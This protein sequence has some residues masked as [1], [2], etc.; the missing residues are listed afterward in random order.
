MRTQ[1][2]A[3]VV[4]TAGKWRPGPGV[5]SWYIVAACVLAEHCFAGISRLDHRAVS[6]A[7]PR[8]R[9]GARASSIP[10]A[11]AGGAPAASGHRCGGG[12]LVAV[13]AHRGA[14]TTDGGGGRRRPRA[15]RWLASPLLVLLA[16]L[17]ALLPSVAAQAQGITL[18][19]DGKIYLGLWS[20]YERRS[21]DYTVKLTT[22]PSADVTVTIS[23]GATCTD[24]GLLTFDTDLTTGGNQDTLT[25][26]SSNWNTAQTVRVSNGIDSDNADDYCQAVHTASGG[27]YVNVSETKMVVAQ[28]FNGEVSGDFT[29]QT[30]NGPEGRD[31]VYRVNLTELPTSDV[32][33]TITYKSGDTDI[34]VDTDAETNGNQNTLTFTVSNYSTLQKVTIKSAEDEDTERGQAIFTH[35][36]SG[37][38][39]E[40]ALSPSR[41]VTLYEVDDDDP[42]AKPEDLSASAGNTQVSL[43]WDQAVHPGRLVIDKWQYR[44]KTTGDYGSWT[45]ISGSKGT[46]TGHTVTGLTNDVLHTFEV[47]AHADVAGESSDEA[48]ATPH[49]PLSFGTASISDYTFARQ[50]TITTVTL[51]QA[52]G[53]VPSLTYSL[54]RTSGTP[55]LPPGLTFTASSR[56]LSGT[57]STLQTATGYT[58]TVTDSASPANTATLTVNIAVE[59]DSQPTLAAVSDQTFHEDSAI[60]NL[61]LPAASGGN[62]PLTYTLAKTGG[63]GIPAGLTFDAS[64]RTLSGTPDDHQ[65]AT[66][67]TYTV[68]DS[69]DD[70]ASQT[71]NITIT[72]DNDPSFGQSTVADQ[73]WAQNKAITNLTLPEATGGDGTTTYTLVRSSGTPT[74]PPGISFNANTRVVSGTPTTLQSD[75]GYTY[76]ATDSDSDTASLTFEITVE[77]DEA[78]T[79]GAVADQT[80]HEDSAITDFVLPEASGGNGTLTYTLT[81]TQGSGLPAGLS[82]DA[83]TRTLSGTPTEHQT[84]TSYTYTVTDSDSDTA[85]QTFD[86][87]ITE[88]NDPSFGSSTIAD[89]TW[90]QNAALTTLTL[91]EATGGDGVTTYTLERTSGTPTLPPGV[92]FDSSS[93]G[94]SGTPTTLQSDVGYTYTAT[95]GDGDTATLTFEITVETD[96]DVTLGA[97]ADQTYHEDSAIT[98]LVLPAAGGGNAPLIYT[99]AKT[100]G[101]GIPAGLTF[102][103]ATR[104]LSGTPD[105]HQTSTGYTYTVTD[106]DGDTA[107]QIFNIT[108]TEDNEPTFG[109]GTVPNQSWAQNEAI[110][111]QTLPA[112][113]GGDGV[114]TYTLART[115]GQPPLPPGI[116]FTATTRLLAGTP[117]TLQ[118]A[119]G[120]TYTATDGDGD[121]ATLTFTIA[122][123]ADS[124]PTLGSVADQ[125]FHEDSAITDLVLPAATNGNAPVS[126]TL[127]KT[128]GSGL[129]AGLTFDGPTRTLSGTPE[130]HQTATGYTYT[131]TD[132]DDDSATATFNITITQDTSPAFANN[133]SIADRVYV[134]TSAI[135]NE[136]FPAATGGQ[137]PLTYSLSP[138]LPTGLTFTA[139]SRELSGTPST[140]KAET[141]Y[142]YTVTDKDGDTDTLTF[143]LTVEEDEQPSFSST[144]TD[145]TYHQNDAITNLVLPAASGGN[146]PLSYTLAKTNDSGI[147]TGLTF[148]ASSRTLSGT[149]TEDQTATGYTYTVTDV[150][151]DTATLTFDIT[152]TEDTD[153]SFGSSTVADQTWTQNAAI[154]NLTLP[155]ATGGE[156]SKTYTLARSS[157]TPTLPPGISFNSTTR[158]VSGTPTTLQSDVGYTYTATDADDDTATLTF[159]I[160]VEADTDPTLAS[161]ANQ[162]FH[163]RSAITDLVLPAATNGNAPFT[164]TLAKTG[165][166]G[167]PAGL[168][169]DA[170]TRTLSGTPTAHQTATSYTYTVTD[171]E[172]DTASV[173]FNITITED[174]DPSFGANMVADQTWTQNDA[175]TNLT[176]PEATGGDGSTTYTL[177]R[178]SGTPTLPPGISFNADTRVVSGTPTTLQSDVGYTYTATDGDDDTATLTFE[179]TVEADTAPTLGAVTD[180]TYHQ[181]SAIADLVLPAATNGNAPLTYTLAKTGGSGIP[182]GLTFDATTRTLSGTPTG[183]QASTSYTYKVTDAQ[184]ESATATFNITITQDNSPS[185]G[186]NTIAD[187]TWTQNAAITNL[188]LP[189]ATGGDGSKTYTL[190]RTSGTPT[191]PP[192]I[193]FN[194]NTRVVSGTP[195][196]LQ[197]AIG[198]TYTAT[199]SDDDTATL[200]FEITVEADTTPTLGSIADQ[201]YFRDTAITNLVLPAAT[202]GNAPFTYSLAK[203]G[204]SGLPTGLSFN[205]GTR[206]LSGTPTVAQTATGYTYTVTDDEDD[207]ATATFDITISV[208]AAPTADAGADQS[209]FEA[210][211]VTLDGTGSSDPENQTLTY[212]WTQVPTP[213]ALTVTNAVTL[214]SATAASPTFTAPSVSANIVLTFS[215]T[216]SDSVGASSAADTV[217]VTVKNQAPAATGL[218]ATWSSGSA[219]LS[220]TNPNDAAVTGWEYRWHSENRSFGSTD[221][222]IAIPSSGASTSSYQTPVSAGGVTYRFQVRALNV[223]GGGAAS[224]TASILA[225]PLAPIGLKSVGGDKSVTIS[226]ADPSDTSI[227]SYEYRRKTTT[228]YSSWT[229]VT[230]SNASTTSV[231]V[232]SLFNGVAYGFQVRARN[233]TGPGGD[234]GDVLAYTI[235]GKPSLTATAGAGQVALSWRDNSNSVGITRWQ[236]RH[237]SAGVTEFGSW[238]DI[239]GSGA[240]TW[241]HTVTGLAPQVEYTFELRGVNPGGAGLASN[242]AKATPT[243]SAVTDVPA[244]PVLSVAVGDAK[245]RLSWPGL[246]DA[247][248]SRFEYKRKTAG[249]FGAVTHMVDSKATTTS[250]DVLSLTNGTTYGFVVRAVNAAGNSAWSNEV[251]AQLFL[252]PG[253]LTATPSDGGA[254]LSWTGNG[255]TSVSAWQ[256]HYQQDGGGYG[257]WHAMSGS[258]AST[259][260]HSVTGLD[261]GHSYTFRIRPVRTGGAGPL[262][263]AAT[264]LLIPAKPTSFTASARDAE[265]VLRWH[266]PNNSSITRWQV[267]T[268][269]GNNAWGGWTDISGS[270]AATT[271]HTATTLTNATVYRFRLRAVNATGN[272]KISDEVTATPTAV[273]PA[274][275]LT[276]TAGNGTATLTWTSGGGTGILRWQFQMRKGSFEFGDDPR[277]FNIPGGASASTHTVTGLDNGTTYGFRVAAVNGSGRGA[278]SNE[279]SATP[280]AVAP[281]APTNLTGTIGDRS[282]ALNWSP[283]DDGGSPITKWQYKQKTGTNEWGDWSDFP[284]NS[285][286]ITGL[287]NGTLYRFKVRGVNA[288]GPGAESDETG[289][290]S[291]S[292]SRPAA[293]TGLTARSVAAT[294]VTLTWTAASDPSISD[295]QY[296]FVTEANYQSAVTASPPENPFISGGWTHVPSATAGTRSYTV[297]NLLASGTYR[298]QV[299][300]ANGHGAGTASAAT[301]ILP[302][303]PAPK[304]TW[305]TGQIT[306]TWTAPSNHGPT[307]SGYTVQWKS[308][309]Q[310]F[311]STRQATA[312]GTSHTIT[313]L[314]DGTE[315]TVRVKAT[316]T[317]GDSGW[318]SEVTATPGANAPLKPTRPRATAGNA[319][320]SLT[321]TSGGNGGSAITGWQY[322]QKADSGSYGDWTNI[323]GSGA[324]TTSYTVPSL[325]NGTT[326]TFRVR[327]VNARGNGIESDESNPVTPSTSGPTVPLAPTNVTAVRG[328][329]QVSLSWTSGGDGGAA[330]TR[331]EYQQKAGGGNYGTW[332]AISNSDPWTTSH[333]VTTL[334]N[335]TQYRFK[336]RAV[337]SVGDGASGESNA[338]TPA[339]VPG[340]PT[341]LAVATDGEG[342]AKVMLEWTAPSDNGGAAVTEYWVQ[343]KSGSQEFSTSR[344]ARTQYTAHTVTG[345]TD[346][347]A[348][349]FRVQAVNAV[350]KGAWSGTVTGTPT[351]QVPDAPPNFKADN[352]DQQLSLTW[353]VPASNGADITGYDVEWRNGP[354]AFSEKTVTETSTTITGLTN[355][356]QYELRVRATNSEGDGPWSQATGFP[357][358][359]PEAPASLVIR[360]YDRFLTF[361]WGVPD[362]NGSAI[363]GYTVQWKTLSE[364]FGDGDNEHTTT[365]TSHTWGS[366]VNGQVYYY[367]VRAT[368]ARGDGPWSATK[369]GVPGH[370]PLKPTLTATGGDTTAALTWTS[371]GDGG[372]PITKWQVRWKKAG[373][374]WGEWTD[375]SDSGPDTTSHTVTGLDNGPQYSFEVRAVNTT[376]EGPASDTVSAYTVPAKPTGFSAAGGTSNATLTWNNPNDG[377]ITGWEYRYKT[378]SGDYGSWTAIANSTATTT[379]ASVSVANGK[380][381]TFQIRA[382]NT[383]GNSPAADESTAL[384]VPAKPAGFSVASGNAQVLLS[385][386]SQSSNTTITRWEVRTKRAI[387][388]WG[389]WTAIANSGAATTSHLV[390]NLDTRTDYRF[391]VRAVNATG[392]GVQ[393]DIVHGRSIA[394]NIRLALSTTQIAED[395][396]AADDHRDGVAEPR[397]GRERHLSAPHQ[398]DGEGGQ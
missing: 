140:N 18:T 48:T 116:T 15:A 211:T 293:P 343:W 223:N 253:T 83:N 99:L 257:N 74:L 233:A 31:N 163:Q 177:A 315:Y 251:A 44:Y 5:P 85:S 226:W 244:A 348:Y 268:K 106:N 41:D 261:N 113:T 133:A 138:A 12:D 280:A 90:V 324:T 291:P 81:K 387:N 110:T 152:I 193:S 169:F 97:V 306:A 96:V 384:M 3:E 127:G 371:G 342:H 23:E 123:V 265:V 382:V 24:S 59:A 252:A 39:Y 208:N 215:L 316:N 104:T 87:T 79:L 168:S 366:L 147:P 165:G 290:H 260:S 279:A 335:G 100:G 204:G 144:I 216:V 378:G 161:V 8:G 151:G 128:G 312:T 301:Q 68:T 26:T 311:D 359:V 388:A 339:T 101:S 17:S 354:G 95:D 157:G 314:T 246:A 121:T 258:G 122:V 145:Q 224:N 72:Q 332:T 33:V 149:P 282:V 118:S 6:N 180:Q 120:Y 86:I 229:T 196:T 363:T 199:D 130:D 49:A 58:Y 370:A 114:T 188:T 73:T 319:Q 353:D 103:A 327:A 225:P 153:P 170:T 255:D 60:T 284:N 201:T 221:E 320:V 247:S 285:Y 398:R 111:N 292:A 93:R 154:T 288:V 171:D 46:D 271:S 92:S 205:A 394:V 273:P 323:P 308:G 38:G 173:T 338:A 345:L 69:D 206:T 333:T 142:T 191:L 276:A 243:G 53:G 70:T 396:A 10:N 218:T 262:S 57:P 241:A 287:T 230:G 350:G 263:N 176:L 125:T 78:P 129:P 390:R 330:I 160:T 14:T 236:Y 275:T 254:S 164:Y 321:W 322:R 166:S 195:T 61:V 355:G 107:S 270:G 137:S 272:G 299:R 383:S 50:K 187:Q 281:A 71:F 156:G 66:G 51:P 356:T 286:T 298:V 250:Y 380:S 295:W 198:Y 64:T 134:R 194:A 203:T 139:S 172:D 112:A 303:A 220:W 222:W 368:N 158:Q 307:I 329:A 1:R 47:R 162:T 190:A 344:Q 267:D 7:A 212:A 207:S 238:T 234:S 245:V 217:Q 297:G 365:E 63:S 219:L 182:A 175:I 94:V 146:A 231:T 326:Y 228:G 256:Y 358:A 242:Q 341:G 88:D 136:T 259:T 352:G 392:D 367:R 317:V 393:S 346:D 381:H 364:E 302:A 167:L 131:A 55:T 132:A 108:I 174:N 361:G 115:S 119:V 249:T 372:S 197:S 32:T 20:V 150:D 235:P 266:N 264:A 148:T 374:P 105:D 373:S 181:R 65:T 277:W 102:D 340:A 16:G 351:A 21:Q 214:S 4:S 143:K 391:R 67:Y 186:A 30:P 52:T 397:A 28:E 117:T 379:S 126:Y 289:P 2:K 77:A 124:A 336:V 184:D 200:T 178:S 34:T 248:I 40:H 183:Y 37:G 22:Q 237:K 159:E 239:P 349:T 82:F 9:S 375:I 109:S 202:S 318:S 189:E 325:T 35:T 389:S 19:W 62:A 310:S 360:T 240:G 328:N 98:D 296:Q 80:Y 334:T 278:V 54:A 227:T 75:I 89:Q 386:T 84:A 76:T 91:P 210:A 376:G 304:L 141:T 42:P 274:P 213:P 357:D 294:R 313:T 377:A 395:D 45:D 25:F 362:S 232:G 179:I 27:G 29:A 155:E 309:A 305:G 43:S 11:P 385:W 185:F 337:N 347:T 36:A 209:L 369:S 300:S 135:T 56:Q 331:W 192:G 13:E 283:G 269:A